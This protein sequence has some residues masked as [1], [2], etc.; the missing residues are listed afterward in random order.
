MTSNTLSSGN[1]S[2]LS[3]LGTLLLIAALAV[4][5]L[6]AERFNLLEPTEIELT[7]A[8]C[9]V[10]QS[11]C[12]A[13][14]DGFSITLES[15]SG[16]VSSLQPTDWQVK[17]EGIESSN[18]LLDLQGMD[19]FMGPNQTAFSPAQDQAGLFRGQSILGA[20][21]TGEMLWQATVLMDTPDGK[22]TTR[23]GFKAK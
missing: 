10:G 1:K 9:D 8:D 4:L 12:T 7:A 20:C 16:K 17:V 22:I 18:V 19:M 21:T 23:F 5:W 13:Q 15:V 14:G 11:A 2:A 6:F 3:L